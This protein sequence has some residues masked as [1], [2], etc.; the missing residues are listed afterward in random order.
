MK[1]DIVKLNVSQTTLLSDFFK[2][3]NQQVVL[4]FFK[5]HEFSDGK[6]KE[7]CAYAGKD[8]YYAAIFENQI[9]AYGMLRGWDEGFEIPS[10]GVCVDPDYQSNHLGIRMTEFLISEARALGSKCVML[11]VNKENRVAITLYKKLGFNLEELNKEQFKGVLA[12]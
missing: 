2:K 9:V 6:A 10:I 5:P 7:I 8:R 12:W 1:I 3:I 4:K 11:K